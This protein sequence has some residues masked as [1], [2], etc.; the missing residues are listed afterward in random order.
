[1][2]SRIFLA[3]GLLACSAVAAAADRPLGRDDILR[4]DEQ[5]ATVLDLDRDASPEAGDHHSSPG[6]VDL[7]RLRALPGSP[8]VSVTRL[9]NGDG[10]TLLKF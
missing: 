10:G 3:L 2:K 9:R 4:R 6:M 1:M 8:S 7:A 5:R